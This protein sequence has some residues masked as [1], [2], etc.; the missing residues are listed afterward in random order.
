MDQ[1]YVPINSATSY[2]YDNFWKLLSH[3]YLKLIAIYSSFKS[4]QGSYNKTLILLLLLDFP[5]A[6]QRG[7]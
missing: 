3:K 7:Y 4:H 5:L 2:L 1:K 6:L